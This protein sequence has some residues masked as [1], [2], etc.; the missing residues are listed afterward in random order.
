MGE[1]DRLLHREGYTIRGARQALGKP[2]G[3]RSA[4]PP[5]RD[6]SAPLFDGIADHSAIDLP[7]IPLSEG[8]PLSEDGEPELAPELAMV[9]ALAVLR[10][11]L[12]SIR[13]RLAEAISLG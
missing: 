3:R 4:A 12:E 2:A 11:H 7:G 6:T 8:G 9:S 5:H 10:T 1:I 13:A